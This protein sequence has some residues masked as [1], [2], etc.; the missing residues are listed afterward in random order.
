MYWKANGKDAPLSNPLRLGLAKAMLKFDAYQL[1]KYAKQGDVR[2]R[3]VM[4]LVHPKG[5]HDQHALFHALAEDTLSPT[6]AGTWEAT[7]GRGRQARD[8]RAADPRE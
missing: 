7:V 8:V 2:L 5:T 4:L 3:D 6:N 1:A